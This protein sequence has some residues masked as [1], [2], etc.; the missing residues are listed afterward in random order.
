MTK[1][2]F[3]ICI[4]LAG[5]FALVSVLF[6]SVLTYTLYEFKQAGHATEIIVNQTVARMIVVKNAQTEFTRALLD[7]RGYLFYANGGTLEVDYQNKISNSLAMVQEIKPQLILPEVRQ[8]AEQLE[9]MLNDYMTYANTRLLPARKANDPQW[10]TIAGEGRP[11]VQ[12]IDAHFLKL[13]EMQK[14]Y[15]DKSGQAVLESSQQNSNL[16]ITAST[17]IVL[18]VIGLVFL[19]SRAMSRRLGE[20][21]QDLAQVGNLDLTGQDV[22]PSHNDEIGDMSIVIIAMRKSL[23]KFVRQIRDNSQTLAASSEELSA[24]AMESL[25][26]VDIVA[27]SI[28]EIATGASQNADNISN[29]SATLE[30][31]SAGSQQISAGASDVNNS[32]QNAV[33]EARKGM[34]MLEQLVIQ[35]EDVNQSMSEITVVTTHLSQGSERIKGIVNVINGIAAQTN[36]L[37]LNAAIEAAR[38]GEAGRGF[39]VVAD[40]VRKLAE[41]SANA[42]KDIAGI[43]SN[44]G[45][46]INSAVATVGQANKEVLKGK[47]STLITQ[48]GFKVIIEKLEGVKIGVE[49]IAVSVNETAKGT[50]TMVISIE[51]ISS[52]AHQ[53]SSNSETV[54]ASAEEQ[55][56]GM[57]EINDNVVNLSNLA[58]DMMTVVNKFKI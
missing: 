57:H 8:E 5:M 22:Q 44:M 30:Q 15:L 32:T 23:T 9:K 45:D 56:A 46:Q 10:I 29:I 26:T 37:A 19:Y 4:Q 24:S 53:T 3:P 28:S 42:T 58:T 18:L 1:R 14:T 16:G 54:A 47:E 7:M 17:F 36:L 33:S 55:S 50:Q 2:R 34:G 31:I 25:R 39:A 35:N 27:Q 11:M 13:S 48:E 43:I 52:V 12:S 6:I 21:S 40:E 49:Q 51:N 38:A 41:Q 20:L